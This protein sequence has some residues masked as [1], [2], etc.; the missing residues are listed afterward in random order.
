MKSKINVILLG[1]LIFLLGSVAG[2]VSHNI[3]WRYFKKPPKPL[4]FIEILARDLKLDADQQVKV[5]AIAKETKADLIALNKKFKPQF[6]AV[7]KDFL[8]ELNVIR[9][10]SDQKIIDILKDDQKAPFKQFLKRMVKPLQ[11]K[12]AQPNEKK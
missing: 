4:S 7:N 1:I 10:R 8:P 3:Y 12:Q 6:D 5:K 2:A 11:I 9:K